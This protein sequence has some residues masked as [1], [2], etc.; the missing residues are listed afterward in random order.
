MRILRHIP[1]DI[2]FEKR[3]AFYLVIVSPY[4]QVKRHLYAREKAE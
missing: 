2:S 4:H 3:Y 1:L